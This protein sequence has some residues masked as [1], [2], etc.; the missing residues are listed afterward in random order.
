MPDVEHQ[1]H[2]SRDEIRQSRRAAVVINVGHGDAGA[3]LVHLAGEMTHSARAR[4]GEIERDGVAAAAAEIALQLQ[5]AGAADPG[6]PPLR[7]G[8][9][10]GPVVSRLGDVYGTTVNI[11][12]RLTSIC[13]P[14][15]VLVDRVMAE[16]LR[17]DDRFSLKSRRPESVWAMC[18]R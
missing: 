16:Q 18:S 6:M 1:R 12:S 9:A 8:V 15:W 14:G 2:A 13:R 3:L 11:A 4:R 10:A 5:E 7:V 17:D